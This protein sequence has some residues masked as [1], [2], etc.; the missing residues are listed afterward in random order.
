LFRAALPSQ[1]QVAISAFDWVIRQRR[2]YAGEY[3]PDAPV[4]YAADSFLASVGVTSA[5]KVEVAAGM[6][7]AYQQQGNLD[8]AHFF[9]RIAERLQPSDGTR[10]KRQEFESALR[11]LV[12]NR[13]RM[14]QI[15]EGIEQTRPV[16]PKLLAQAE[17]RR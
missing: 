4:A 3:D 9:A 1:P 11:I 10:G 15:H 2:G 14:P 7:S 8:Q 6:A 13:T 12:E 17:V 5:E 16:R